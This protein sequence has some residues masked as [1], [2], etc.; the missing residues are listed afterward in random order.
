MC[1]TAQVPFH[2]KVVF[3]DLKPLRDRLGEGRE[4]TCGLGAT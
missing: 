4:P 2:K 3:R 1:P